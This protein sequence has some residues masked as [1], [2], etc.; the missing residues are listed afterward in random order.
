MQQF[1]LYYSLHKSGEEI[2]LITCP[3]E[4]QPKNEQ[5]EDQQIEQQ[6]PA[7]KN[8][9]KSEEQEQIEK[10]KQ[11]RELMRTPPKIDQYKTKVDYD[12][13]P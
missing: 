9:Q 7:E 10:Q 3:T 4:R 1:V 5:D 6:Q 8:E 11:Y 13:H 12:F 2:V